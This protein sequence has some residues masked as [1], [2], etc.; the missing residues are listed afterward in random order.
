MKNIIIGNGLIGNIVKK[1]LNN[2]L[3]L[4]RHD[5]WPEKINKCIICA[6]TS[7]R[8]LVEQ[9]PQKDYNDVKNIINN[10][11]KIKPKVTILISTVD[12]Q[13]ESNTSYSKN[14]KI[15]ENNYDYN[16]ILRLPSLI[17]KSIIKN[18]LYD[19]KNNVFLESHNLES[20]LQWYDLC[21]LGD[22]LNNCLEKKI[23]EYNLVSEPVKNREILN[24]FFPEL[25]KKQF[26]GK[27]IYNYNVSNNGYYHCSKDD[28]HKSIEKYLKIK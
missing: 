10:I 2:S 8:L 14:R 21:N 16:V 12:T 19:L 28:I 17:H 27:H 1:K 11:V 26:V 9:N 15:L 3:I 20:L 22:D 4:N 13:I 23:K 5:Q 6:P 25:E 7:N 18:F 24:N